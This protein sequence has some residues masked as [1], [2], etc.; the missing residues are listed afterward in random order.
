MTANE[1]F[2]A[3]VAWVCVER[4]YDNGE[5]FRLISSL[6]D[7]GRCYGAYHP[8][9]SHFFL[10]F[11]FFYFFQRI[12]LFRRRNHGSLGT[13]GFFFLPRLAEIQ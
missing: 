1:E 4:N 13:W 3:T 9:G 12:G 5:M 7:H 10:L 6:F 8:S 2:R 11:L